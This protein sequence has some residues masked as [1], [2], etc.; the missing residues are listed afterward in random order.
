VTLAQKTAE[1]LLEHC[2]DSMIHVTARDKQ[3]WDAK[4]GTAEAT[5]AK[6]GLMAAAD[7]TK[8]DGVAAGAEVNQNAYS[9]I[10]VGNATVTANGKTATFMLEAGNN[11]TLSADNAA[12]KIIITADRDG[13]N[14]DTVDGYHAASLAKASEVDDLKKSVSD[15]KTAVAGAVTAKGVT[16]AASA[17]FATIAANIGKISTGVDTSDATAT[18]GEVLSGKTFYAK[19][20]KIT[21]KMANHGAVTQALNA[22]GSYTIPA[23]YHNGSGK[24]TAKSL[25]DQTSANA[26]AADIMSSKTAWVNGSKITGALSAASLGLTADKIVEGNTI[27][28]IAG[29]GGGIKTIKGTE[30]II[31]E[32]SVKFYIKLSDY[33]TKF[34]DFKFCKI[35]TVSKA[36]S[37]A[38]VFYHDYLL[39]LVDNGFAN[40]T[41][42]S[43][44]AIGNRSSS[45]SVDLPT[46]LFTG[47]YVSVSPTTKSLAVESLKRINGRY[48]IE[49]SATIS[50][51][52]LNRIMVSALG[53]GAGQ[54]DCVI[55]YI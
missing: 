41:N 25:A 31:Y 19:G 10:K 4:A 38:D 50:S 11:I 13:G 15:G 9:S 6:A 47:Q 32:D 33:F 8:L 36:A 17:T 51:S 18:D 24:V 49:P 22:G 30:V 39:L 2:D 21:G 34:T 37:S 46:N 20:A 26:A 14:A 42:I 54:A 52:A 27:L 29:T 23:G 16:T 44:T 43:I 5:A 7:K 1:A 28:G 53:K 48:N 35:Y 3:E 40:T 45:G 55:E 12:K